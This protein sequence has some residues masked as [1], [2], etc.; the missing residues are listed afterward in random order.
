MASL[1]RL[2]VAAGA[3]VVLLT[4]CGESPSSAPRAAGA[5]SAAGRAGAVFAPGSGERLL[6]DA[7][8]DG[9]GKA[10]TRVAVKDRDGRTR[11]VRNVRGAWSAPTVVPGQPEGI[12]WDG[13]RVV[14]VSR[15]DPGRMLTIDTTTKDR[16]PRVVALSRRFAYDGVSAT[17]DRLFLT[18][19]ADATG[20]PAYR[21]RRYDIQ[22]GNLAPEPIVDK[23]EGE[24]AMIGRPV[25][26][27]STADFIYTVYERNRDR[28]FVH[29]LQSAGDFALCI[30][31]PA[32]RNAAARP[33]WSAV[34]RAQ[35][36]VIVSNSVLRS[37]YLLADGRMTRVRYSARPAR[38]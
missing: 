37:A 16:P 18:Q 4:G 3:A 30:D 31:L 2:T 34:R 22:T 14:L 6:V 24:E 13:S 32:D 38:R 7:G 15:T 28:P 8:R 5:V 1:R 21:I 20:A 27:A 12:S 23:L 29:A 19:L 36:A 35:D 10:T 11:V 26:R 33:A 9:A 17:G 25:A